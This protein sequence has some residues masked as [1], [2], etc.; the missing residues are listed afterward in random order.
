MNSH[1]INRICNHHFGVPYA[2][3]GNSEDYGVNLVNN[4]FITSITCPMDGFGIDNC[5]ITTGDTC[6]T[7]AGVITCY[8]SCIKYQTAFL[9]AG[10]GNWYLN[11]PSFQ[12]G[13]ATVCDGSGYIPICRN[14]ITDEDLHFICIQAGYYG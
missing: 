11:Y 4:N 3:V 9:V 10:H 7:P 6:D 2:I 12:T 13:R 5:D 1:I 14:D 8:S